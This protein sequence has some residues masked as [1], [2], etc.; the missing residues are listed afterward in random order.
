MDMRGC[1]GV[2]VSGC[3]SSINGVWGYDLRQGLV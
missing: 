3:P 1:G 2:I